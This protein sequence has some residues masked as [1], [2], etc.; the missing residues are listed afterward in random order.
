MEKTEILPAE[1]E[2]DR[3]KKRESEVSICGQKYLNK[4]IK[5]NRN[6]KTKT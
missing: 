2:G 1:R 6:D 4:F 5:L 3:A